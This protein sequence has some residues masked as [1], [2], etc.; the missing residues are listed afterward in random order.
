MFALVQS[1]PAPDLLAVEFEKA[2][3]TA[4]AR[5][6]GVPV[7]DSY[8]DGRALPRLSANGA[9]TARRSKYGLA[10]GSITD[11]SPKN[12]RGTSPG[13]APEL[14]RRDGRWPPPWSSP[15]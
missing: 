4:L 3:Q 10:D 13:Q 7:L 1:H 9:G 15:K 5:A 14:P 6:E 8:I 11:H 2:A 12:S